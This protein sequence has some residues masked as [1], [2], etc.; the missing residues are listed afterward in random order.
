MYA[1]DTRTPSRNAEPPSSPETTGNSCLGLMLMRDIAVSI[2]YIPRSKM[3]PDYIRNL[4]DEDQRHGVTA[5]GKC[6]EWQMNANSTAVVEKRKL[7]LNKR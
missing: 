4:A 7:S 6:Q 5:L 3:G 1:K 2:N